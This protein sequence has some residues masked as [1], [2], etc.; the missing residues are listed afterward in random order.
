MGTPDDEELTMTPRAPLLACALLALGVSGQAFASVQSFEKPDTY[1]NPA[2]KAGGTVSVLN[3]VGHVSLVPATDGVFSID[4][5][6]VAAADTAQAAQELAGKIKFDVDASGSSVSYTAHY[7]LDEYT[8]YYY[9]RGSGFVIGMSRSSTTYMGERVQIYD[10]G[11]GSGANLHVDFVIHVPK[12]VKVTVDNKIGKLEAN[13]VN[14]TLSLKSSSGDIYA[15]NN[16]GSLDADTGS[17]DIDVKGHSGVLDLDTGSGDVTV[18]HQKSGDIKVDTGSGDVK[19]A[20]LGG[21]LKAETG[22]GDVELL[23]FN[24]AGADLETG[25][26][27][28]KLRDVAGS[29][30]LSTGSGDINGSGIKAGQAVECDTGSGG[31]ELDGDF[32]AVT[33]L[34][35]DTGSGDIVIHT[36]AVPSL[37]ITATSD[38]GDVNV[39]LPGMQ[40][41]VARSH[42]IRADVNGAKGTAELEAGSGD[43]TFSKH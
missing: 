11:F 43:V 33:R 2:I 25:S 42:S 23:D 5:K 40:N 10:G 17:G 35:A 32:S 37:H 13:G 24:G 36:S 15:E 20:S 4:T 1:K 27:E 8:S 34:M 28:I 3:L 21:T 22:S 14:G 19:L 16:S 9:A 39:D 6:V 31:V 29:L 12:D 30:K 18:D 26:G 7:P 41:V 38:S